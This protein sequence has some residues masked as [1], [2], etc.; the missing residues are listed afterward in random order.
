MIA[1]DVTGVLISGGQVRGVGLFLFLYS[2]DTAKLGR[3]LQKIC[4]TGAPV[5]DPL[6]FIAWEVESSLG[7]ANRHFGRL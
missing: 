2:T 3:K 5:E 6:S 4:V 7:T 1:C